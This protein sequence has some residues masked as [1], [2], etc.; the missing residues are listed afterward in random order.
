MEI[1]VERMKASELN[2]VAE[3]AVRE[4]YHG[5]SIA[6][7]K[8]WIK[9]VGDPTKVNPYVQWFVAK[10]ET[11]SKIV[12]FVG[13]DAFDFDFK[14]NQVML[15][16]TWLAVDREYHRRKIGTELVKTALKEVCDYWR[17]AGRKPVMVF[18]ETDEHDQRARSFYEKVYEEPDT[19]ILKDVWGRGG[20]TVFYFKK[21]DSVD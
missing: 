3:I 15:I 13:Y 21:L 19:K 11:D 9:S 16:Q 14:G 12:G 6:E 18:V 8:Q 2:Q 20:G 10:L 5:A 7:M 17:G 1:K 4:I